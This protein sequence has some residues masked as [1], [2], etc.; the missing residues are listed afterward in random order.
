MQRC[1]SRKWQLWREKAES[2]PSE[3]GLNTA[4]EPLQALGV[5]VKLE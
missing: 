5:L 4:R 1:K 3:I 2:V